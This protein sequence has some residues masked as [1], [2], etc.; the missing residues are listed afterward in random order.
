[1]LEETSTKFAPW[2]LIPANDKPFGRIAAFRILGERLGKG[3][4]LRPRPINP[5]LFKEAKRILDLSAGDIRRAA[6]E[7]D[8]KIRSKHDPKY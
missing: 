5:R 3:V 1:M 2:Y 4:P 7:A 6:K 8:R